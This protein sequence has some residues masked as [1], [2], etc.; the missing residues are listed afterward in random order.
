MA[1]ATVRGCAGAARS[2]SCEVSVVRAALAIR[3]LVSPTARPAPA[4]REECQSRQQLR[5]GEPEARGDRDDQRCLRV[6]EPQY[7]QRQR[8]RTLANSKPPRREEGKITEDVWPRP[9]GHV[10]RER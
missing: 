5:H 6:G 1:A 4:K 10:I 8:Q 3:R 9:R 2:F 7:T